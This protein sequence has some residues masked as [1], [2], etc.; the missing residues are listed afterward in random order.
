MSPT[1]A[2]ERA[3]TLASYDAEAEI[4]DNIHQMQNLIDTI[5][6]AQHNIQGGETVANDKEHI[7]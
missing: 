5:A 1:E 7:E 6:H 3:E 2:S 4:A